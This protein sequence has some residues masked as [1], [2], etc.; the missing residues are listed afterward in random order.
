MTLELIWF[1]LLGVMLIIYSVL[2]GF[3]LGVGSLHMAVASTD[4]ERKT[5]IKAI[6]P[7]WD[8]NEVWLLAAGGTLF[9]GFPAV[10][11]AALSG[12]Y[13]A[14]MLM[15][16]LLIFRAIAIELRSQFENMLWKKTW[17]WAFTVSS[18]LLSLVL[19]AALGNVLRGVPMNES[20][21][22]FAPLITD[23]SVDGGGILDWY[24]VLVGV[25][26]VVAFTLHGAL[27]LNFKTDAAVAQR[28]R[29][30]AARLWAGLLVLLILFVWAT[31]QIRPQIAQNY[32]QQPWGLLLPLAA[33]VSFF[34]ILI[35][36]VLEKNRFALI[37]S[38]FFLAFV[39]LA[40]VFGIYPYILPARIPELGLNI[41]LVHS[42]A[43]SMQVALYWWIPGV[44]LALTYF[45]YMYSRLPKTVETNDD[46]H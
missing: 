32:V 1:L 5:V 35:F 9:L 41:H 8:G 6:G 15:L 27:W 33:A 46:V 17:D 3:D 13:Q 45:W 43:Y 7:V 28:S 19:G 34:K 44:I 10:L 37:S 4:Q 20:G 26:T 2:D 23:L 30:Y 39:L 24:T 42:A 40:M 14:L 18:T 16:W 21:T 36:L 11:A 25:S 29:M 38:G 12:L 31:L 22:F